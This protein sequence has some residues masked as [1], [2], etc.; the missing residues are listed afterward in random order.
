MPN[1]AD[2]R[3]FLS[4]SRADSTYAASQRA[5]IEAEGLTLWQDITHMESGASWRDQIA[6]RLEAPATEHMVLMVSRTAMASEEVRREWRKARQE[7]VTVHPVIVQDAFDDEDM[8]KL[9][10]WMR[11]ITFLNLETQEDFTRL[12]KALEG[13]SQQ[14]RVPMMAPMPNPDFVL[15]KDEGEALL[16][17]LLAGEHAN[18][19]ITAALR[20]AGGY[21]KT[22]LAEWLANQEA[23]QD[24]FY[25]GVLWV[26]LGET[27]DMVSKLDELIRMLTGEASGLTS[28]NALQARLGEAIGER[29]ML[30]VIDDA[31]RES[32]VK[33]LEL[34]AANLT[35]LVTTRFDD[36]LP[37]GAHKVKV[38]A[39]KP[40]EAVEFLAVKL[41]IPDAEVKDNHPALTASGPFVGG[42]GAGY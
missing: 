7:G 34:K 5:R 17:H 40:A 30:L 1:N 9:P 13:P 37:G 22:A 8:Q 10:G 24:A 27:P 14:I 35:R 42:Y 21:G 29:H 11:A 19:G 38:D 36:T 4:Y 32:D 3:I 6:E 12:I 28:L 33:A 26:E 15:R 20:G 25:D 16:G 31:W 2:P 39:M 23:V 18:I 41:P